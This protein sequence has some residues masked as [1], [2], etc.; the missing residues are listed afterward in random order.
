MTSEILD[1][2]DESILNTS[3]NRNEQKRISNTSAYI[4]NTINSNT[5]D[6]LFSNLNNKIDNLDYTNFSYA[7]GTNVTYLADHFQNKKY[8]NQDVTE[9]PENVI[10]AVKIESRVKSN[11]DVLNIYDGKN[12]KDIFPNSDNQRESLNLFEATPYAYEI[13]PKKNDSDS[14]VNNYLRY[15][16]FET[17]KVTRSNIINNQLTV[18]SKNTQDEKIKVVGSISN[19]NNQIL[20]SD[21]NQ[22]KIENL[23]K[24][25]KIATKKTIPTINYADTFNEN[26]IN[27]VN[28]INNYEN[29]FN[30]I[31]N[32]ILNSNLPKITNLQNM[33]CNSIN[34]IRI[35]SSPFSNITKFPPKIN[36]PSVTQFQIVNNQNQISNSNYLEYSEDQ[37]FE[38][39][40]FFS[41]DQCLCRH[42]QK[43]ITDNS[44]FSKKL[45]MTLKPKLLELINDP[46]GNYLIQKLI[47]NIDEKKIATIIDCVSPTFFE[48]CSSS[49]GTRVIQK[50][51]ENLKTD[52]LFDKFKN[53]FTIHLIDIAKDINANHIIHKFISTIKS[54]FNNFIYEIIKSN[55]D[56]IAKDK[57]GCCVI[58]KCIE[59]ADPVQKVK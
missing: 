36:S 29:L 56:E 9:A 32:T 42:L 58:Q 38:N 35:E 10:D 23:N 34:M 33:P 50:L 49:H 45:F 41:K 7:T 59:C 12:N 39:A 20:N 30:K 37:L 16:N 24:I 57:H 14:A 28:S 6:D 26:G 8:F 2:I 4:N 48:V 54:P 17:S 22:K 27:N 46:F 15:D 21:S 19:F 52:L 53:I 3:L 43:K 13:D 55:L 5:T 18:Q 1:K 25:N 44:A 31:P 40:Y 11:K 51:I 47:E